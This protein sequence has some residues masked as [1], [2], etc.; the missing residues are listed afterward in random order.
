MPYIAPDDRA[1]ID[2]SIDDLLGYIDT[3]GKLNY[4]VTKLASQYIITQGMGYSTLNE[5]IG[6]LECAKQE[7]YR[8]VAVPYE[9]KKCEENGDVFD[10]E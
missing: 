8:R 9:D 7:L 1:V 3:P 10:V 4:A 5:I 6:V 2:N